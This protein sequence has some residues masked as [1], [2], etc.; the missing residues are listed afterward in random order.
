MRLL[1]DPTSWQ[2]TRIIDFGEAYFSYP[3]H[4][5]R[6]FRAPED[7]KAVL[8]GYFEASEPSKEFMAVWRVGCAIADIAAIALSPECRDAA[9]A[10]LDRILGESR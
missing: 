4:D 5:L 7:R 1:A 9:V 8:A 6:R 10:E 2:L 3:V